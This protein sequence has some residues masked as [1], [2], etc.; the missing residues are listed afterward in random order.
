MALTVIGA[1][2]AAVERDGA[3]ASASGCAA[4][5][6]GALADAAG[7]AARATSGG[8]DGEAHAASTDGRTVTTAQNEAEAR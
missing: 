5:D 7:V 3:P 8:C 1:D 6:R 4:A 2:P